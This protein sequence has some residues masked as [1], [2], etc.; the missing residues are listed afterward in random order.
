MSDE[1]WVGVKVPQVSSK[2]SANLSF[3]SSEQICYL[4]RDDVTLMSWLPLIF[5]SSGTY[6]Y[7]GIGKGVDFSWIIVLQNQAFAVFK[8]PL[9][10]IFKL[11][12]QV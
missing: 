11:I 2:G 9:K 7:K 4:F 5:R 12:A 6:R 8:F 3:T 10:R 1:S